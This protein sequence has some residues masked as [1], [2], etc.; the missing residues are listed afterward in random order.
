V[1]DVQVKYD[2][3]VDGLRIRLKNPRG[4]AAALTAS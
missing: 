2:P 3:R 1:S 4:G